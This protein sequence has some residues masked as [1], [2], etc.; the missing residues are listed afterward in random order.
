MLLPSCNASSKVVWVDWWACLKMR[1]HLG[2]A[3]AGAL[4]DPDPLEDRVQRGPDR[5][6]LK[7]GAGRAVNPR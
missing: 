1:S 5:T 6:D 4:V 3:G 7:G 2:R